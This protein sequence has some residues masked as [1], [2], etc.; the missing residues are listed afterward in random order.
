MKRFSVH[1]GKKRGSFISIKN[2]NSLHHIKRDRA[3]SCVLSFLRIFSGNGWNKGD[4]NCDFLIWECITHD[5][6]CCNLQ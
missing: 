1:D 3:P 4:E 6:L 2:T 5:L